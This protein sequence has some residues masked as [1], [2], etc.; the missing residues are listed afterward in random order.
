MVGNVL[1]LAALIIGALLGFF[2]SLVV[3][4]LKH[5][6]L[7]A[8]RLID[9][10]FEARKAVTKK[11]SPL[12]NIELDVEFSADSRI[13]FRNTVARLYYLHYD[14]LPREILDRLTLLDTC[15]CDPDNGPYGVVKGSIVALESK[16]ISEFIQT[17]SDYKGAM[18]Y[19]S[20]AL[21]TKKRVIRQ[22]QVIKLH[23]RSVLHALNNYTSISDLLSMIKRL[24]KKS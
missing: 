20:M 21:N 16:Q 24:K 23:A 9:Q 11:I 18:L 10:Y 5:R 19:A 6:R 22:N 3:S 7:I 4:F 2:S 1:P 14:F 17:T 13:E 15:L 8:L 12:T